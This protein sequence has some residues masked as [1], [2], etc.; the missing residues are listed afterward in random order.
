MRFEALAPLKDSAWACRSKWSSISHGLGPAPRW[1]WGL[2]ALQRLREV[3][4]W[5]KPDWSC[6]ED[7]TGVGAASPDVWRGWGRSCLLPASAC[8]AKREAAGSVAAAPSSGPVG[9]VLRRLRFSTLR[10]GCCQFPRGGGRA[11]RFPFL[12]LTPGVSV[13]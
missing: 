8:R 9:G 13:P 4:G 3:Q 2:R 6:Q 12:S 7:L 5:P 10:L 11:G 1:G